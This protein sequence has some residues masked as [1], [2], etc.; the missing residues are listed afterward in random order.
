MRPSRNTRNKRSHC[1]HVVST[2]DNVLQLPHTQ[3]IRLSFPINLIENWM[4]KEQIINR[5]ATKGDTGPQTMQLKDE[6]I[7]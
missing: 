7:T 5:N 2:L 6:A 3:R 1:T 4:E